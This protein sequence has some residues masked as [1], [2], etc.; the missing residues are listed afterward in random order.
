ML[1]SAEAV[2]RMASGVRL[3]SEYELHEHSKCNRDD[4]NMLSLNVS[5][6][7][8][9]I[10]WASLRIVE[11]RRSVSYLMKKKS[12]T[13]VLRIETGSQGVFDVRSTCF[14][15]PEKKRET[16][17]LKGSWVFIISGYHYSCRDRKA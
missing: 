11:A 5:D 7:M 3:Q 16:Q 1:R 17:K 2:Y 4:F 13:K 9:I 15:V 8:L 10:F 6:Q 12:T 14:G